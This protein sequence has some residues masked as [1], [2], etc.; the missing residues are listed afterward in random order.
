MCA[1]RERREHHVGHAVAG[2]VGDRGR[3]LTLIEREAAPRRSRSTPHFTAR[4]GAR[5]LGL[6]RRRGAADVVGF[7]GLDQRIAAV[8]PT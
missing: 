4:T 6:A 7:V 8:D 5:A 3:G 1:G 2:Q